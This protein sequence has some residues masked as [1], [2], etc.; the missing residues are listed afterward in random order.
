MS[1]FVASTVTFIMSMAGPLRLHAVQAPAKQ[2]VLNIMDSRDELGLPT[3]GSP[4][5]KP[6]T[7]RSTTRRSSAGASHRLGRTTGNCSA[8]HVLVS[9]VRGRSMSGWRS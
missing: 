3:K 4:Y 6:L 2:V 1:T 8:G 5:A 7:K 9:R